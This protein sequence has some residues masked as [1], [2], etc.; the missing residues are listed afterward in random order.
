MR[1]AAPVATPQ[2]KWERVQAAKAAALEGG[3]PARV[4]KHHEKARGLR[5]QRPVC[6]C[7]GRQQQQQQRQAASSMLAALASERR[8][9]PL[10]PRHTAH[11]PQGKLTARERLQLLFDPGSFREAGGLVT[12]RCHDFG[13]Q[14]QQHFGGRAG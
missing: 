11:P 13:M 2:D 1:P 14:E 5:W 6:I 8:R 3:G 12:H 7:A 9:M 10:N 4:A